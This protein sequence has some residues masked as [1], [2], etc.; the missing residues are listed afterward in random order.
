MTRV[1]LVE[2][3]FCMRRS[4][5]PEEIIRVI[6]DVFDGFETIVRSVVC[7]V[8]WFGVDVGLYRGSARSPLLFALIFGRLANG[9]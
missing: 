4:T 1:R 9:V 5:V 8:E 2:P 7:V 3:W 6:Q